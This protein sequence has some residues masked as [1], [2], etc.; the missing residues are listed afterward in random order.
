MNTK[1]KYNI[2]I[3]N[4]R[5]VKFSYPKISRNCCGMDRLRNNIYMNFMVV[6][7]TAVFFVLI[8]MILIPKLIKNTKICLK[9]TPCNCP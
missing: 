3:I 7:G 9:K 2:T 5:N 6:F 4:I 8:R 1:M